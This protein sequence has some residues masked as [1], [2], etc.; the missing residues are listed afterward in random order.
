M[1]PL[2]LAIALLWKQRQTAFFE[3]EKL[4]REKLSAFCINYHEM[5]S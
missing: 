3:K 1:R 4:I 5:V 2:G